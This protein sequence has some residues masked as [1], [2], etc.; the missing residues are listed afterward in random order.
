MTTRLTP[1]QHMAIRR[2]RAA[3]FVFDVD[4]ISTS[5]L[6]V[7]FNRTAT[8]HLFPLH[9]GTGLLLELEMRFT[10]PFQFRGFGLRAP[11]LRGGGT[12]S[13]FEPEEEGYCFRAPGRILRIRSGLVLN[14]RVGPFWKAQGRYRG[15]LVAELN[16][17]LDGSTVYDGATL[18]ITDSNGVVYPFDVGQLRFGQ[19]P[20]EAPPAPAAPKTEAEPPATPPKLGLTAAMDRCLEALAK[21]RASRR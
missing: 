4:D 7:V 1:E 15:Y 12:W 2:L 18:S 3:G 19:L 6:E 17:A 21:E 8:A 20:V 16:D 13:E 9:R 10:S 14:H 11:W 5:V